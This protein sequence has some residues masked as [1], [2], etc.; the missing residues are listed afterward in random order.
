MD[1]VLL[2]RLVDKPPSKS[3]PDISLTLDSGITFDNC[4]CLN[5]KILAHTEAAK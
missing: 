2:H 5:N 1:V 4:L 3:C